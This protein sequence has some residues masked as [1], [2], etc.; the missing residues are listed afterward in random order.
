[1]AR[2]PKKEDEQEKASAEAA[3]EDP[4]ALD[5]RYKRITAYSTLAIAALIAIYMIVSATV[6][7][8]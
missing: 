4:A 8:F 2:K 1:M 7:M 6:W 5:Q 3:P